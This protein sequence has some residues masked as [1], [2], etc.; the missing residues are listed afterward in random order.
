MREIITVAGDLLDLICLREYGR[1][2]GTVET[3]LAANSGLSAVPQPFA[4]GVR[5]QLPDIVS[6]HRQQQTVALWN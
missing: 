3:V 1:H 2:K 5:I 6:P 4:A